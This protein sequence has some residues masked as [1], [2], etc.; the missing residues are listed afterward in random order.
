M[1]NECMMAVPR[2]WWHRFFPVAPRPEIEGDT[3]TYLT[4]EVRIHADWRDRLRF[5]VSGRVVV[6]V[7]T[8]TDVEVQEAASASTFHVEPPW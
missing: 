6:Q 5:L 8:Y 1:I 3:R 7:R 2:P 4:T